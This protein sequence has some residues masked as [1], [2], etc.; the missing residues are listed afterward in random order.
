VTPTQT[1]TVTETATITPTETRIPTQTLTPTSKCV[2]SI[3]PCVEGESCAIQPDGR[4]SSTG[5]L[6]IFLPGWVWFLAR[7]LR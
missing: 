1:P 6:W 4:R 5:L 3:E 7:R 2:G